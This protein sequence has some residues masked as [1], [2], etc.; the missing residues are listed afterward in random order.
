MT[1]KTKFN[2][3][4]KVY[5]IYN[6]KVYYAPIRSINILV[7]YT[8]SVKIK[9]TVNYDSLTTSLCE[10]SIFKTKEELLKSL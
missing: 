5:F 8:Y 3:D 4:D 2:V 6:N 7:T 9:Y 10:E 1:V